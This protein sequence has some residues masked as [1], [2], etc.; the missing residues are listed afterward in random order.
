MPLTTRAQAQEPLTQTPEEP[1]E[2]VIWVEDRTNSSKIEH[3]EA[4]IRQILGTDA[5][6][7][8]FKI[9]GLMSFW[10]ATF[11]ASLV[12]EIERLKGVSKHFLSLLLSRGL[13]KEAFSYRTDWYLG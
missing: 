3:T 6:I 2:H 10:L 4:A 7:Q 9:G 13:R 12:E 1:R 11:K 8:K 5:E